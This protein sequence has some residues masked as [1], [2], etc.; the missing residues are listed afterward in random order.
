MIRAVYFLSRV[1]GRIQLLSHA[2]IAAGV[3]MNCG[4]CR[5]GIAR[6][7]ARRGALKTFN[8]AVNLCSFFVHTAITRIQAHTSRRLLRRTRSHAPVVKV[9]LNFVKCARVPRREPTVHKQCN[10]ILYGATDDALAGGA[11]F[12]A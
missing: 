7:A 1:R 2:C 10:R 5:Q 9:Q 3:I 11:R 6:N 12:G 4:T 8:F